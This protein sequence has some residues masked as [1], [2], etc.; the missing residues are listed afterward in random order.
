MKSVADDRPYRL[1]V[2]A[3]ILNPE[4]QVWIG[5]RRPRKGEDLPNP[6]QM[7]QGGVDK[8]EDPTAAVLREVAEETGTAKVTLLAESDGWLTYDL[9][10][11]ISRQAWK[12]RYR[13]QKQKWFALRFDGDDTDIDISADKKPEFLDWRWAPLADLPGLVVPFKRPLY[14]AVVETFAHLVPEDTSNT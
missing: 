9:P 8:G 12:G 6:W 5:Q 7:P 2:G 13:G 4:H 1:G 14:H 10:P 3:V 11:E